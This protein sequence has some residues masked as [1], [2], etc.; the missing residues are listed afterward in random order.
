[1]PPYP[2]LFYIKLVTYVHNFKAVYQ[3]EVFWRFDAQIRSTIR[4]IKIEA[5]K[6]YD[7]YL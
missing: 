4:V 3:K 7:V 2:V 6:K 1:M 5:D